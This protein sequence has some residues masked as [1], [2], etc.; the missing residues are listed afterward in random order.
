[1]A[2]QQHDSRHYFVDLI[3]ENFLTSR[4]MSFTTKFTLEACG[5]RVGAYGNRKGQL[6][7]LA[8]W[9]GLDAGL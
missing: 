2:Y 6:N 9:H 8:F 3:D 4:K 7:K 5:N 1:M